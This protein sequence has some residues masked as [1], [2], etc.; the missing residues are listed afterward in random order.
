MLLPRFQEMI[1]EIFLCL[2]L[3]DTT[4]PQ[5]S[6]RAVSTSLVPPPPSSSAAIEIVLTLVA[7]LALGGVGYFLWRRRQSSTAE[8]KEMMLPK[9]TTYPGTYQS[10]N[11]A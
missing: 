10:M 11:S 6:M 1:F 4:A 9:E 2:E 3:S 8:I 7:L 5:C